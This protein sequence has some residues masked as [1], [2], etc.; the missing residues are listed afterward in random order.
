MVYSALP[1]MQDD[2]KVLVL[3]LEIRLSQIFADCEALAYQQ[4]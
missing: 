1:D 2:L 3:M 4:G